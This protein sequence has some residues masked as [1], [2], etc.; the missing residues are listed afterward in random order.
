MIDQL[1]HQFTLNQEYAR[2]YTNFIQEYQNLNHM[3]LV[4]QKQLASSYA[5]YLPH[6]GVLR[7]QSLITK[8]RVVW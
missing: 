5:Y 2:A 7:K 8:L 1:F 4:P 6:H 3:R